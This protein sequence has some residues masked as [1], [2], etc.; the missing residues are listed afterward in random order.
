M[1]ATEFDPFAK[2]ES[3]VTEGPWGD[4]PATPTRIA[5]TLKAASTTGA[6]WVIVEGGTAGA[7]ADELETADSDRLIDNTVEAA[8]RLQKGYAEKV[9]DVPATTAPAKPAATKDEAPGGESRSCKHGEMVYRTGST[10]G[11][12]WRA[13]MCPAPKG[14][15]TQCKPEFLR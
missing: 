9:G 10:G 12:P 13:F 7:V 1:A 14:D 15:A 4:A 2:N 11:K 8:V 6:P 5:V 3:N